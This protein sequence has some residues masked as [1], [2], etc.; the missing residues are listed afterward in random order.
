[1]TTAYA[2]RDLP[3]GYYVVMEDSRDVY[4]PLD[5]VTQVLALLDRLPEGAAFGFDAADL[6][7]SWR[8]RKSVVVLA[9]SA[10]PVPRP[11]R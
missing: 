4:G 9:P 2:P 1:M 3:D 6:R 10:A 11:N 8:R 5:N 7:R